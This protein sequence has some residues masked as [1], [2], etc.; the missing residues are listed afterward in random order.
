MKV[1]VLSPHS[2]CEGV[3]KAFL[4]AKKAKREH[5]SSKIYLLGSLVHNEDATNQLVK[6]GFALIDERKENLSESLGKI[7]D[8]SVVVF[9]AHGHPKQYEKK[10]KEKNLIVYDATCE[11]V[12]K[13]LD[14]IDYFTHNQKDIIF[15]GEK[16]HLEAVAALSYGDKV[17][18]MDS[19][20][21]NDFDFS[22]INDFAPTFITQT[23]M[24]EDEVRETG[25]YILAHKP[26]TFIIDGRCESTKRRQFNFYL[27]PKEAD[28]IVVLGS[29]ASNNTMKLVS[30][31]KE[32]HPEAR[33]FRATNLDE[34]KKYN[35]SKF[36][37][38]ILATGASTSPNV[39]NDCLNYL[40]K[41]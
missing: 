10:A 13:N 21:L 25:K 39:F 35:L 26:A 36:H 33:V 1:F 29:L 7:P 38:A 41:I 32:S 5:P 15:L 22:K 3:V 19:K 30:I 37:Y 14:T 2:Y 40:K 17:H 34:L 8:G 12:K 16:N 20:R 31:G 27:A 11:F 23:T 28:L 18:L 4:I 9:S 6:D 24:S